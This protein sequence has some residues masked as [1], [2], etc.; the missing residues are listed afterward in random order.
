MTRSAQTWLA[1]AAGAAFTL[2]VPACSEPSREPGAASRAGA[3]GEPRLGRAASP[4]QGGATEA[5]SRFAVALVDDDGGICSG[6]LI[7][8]NLVLTARHCVADDDGGA[9][10]DCSQD[11]FEAPLPASIFRVDTR[12]DADFATAAHEVTQIFVPADTLFCGNDIA[13]V[14]LATPVDAATATP[15]VPAIDPPLTDRATYGSTITAIGYGTT[16]PSASDD[17]KRRRRDGIA[18]TCV[19]GDATLGCSLSDFD[20]TARELGAGDGLCSGDSGSGAYAPSSLVAGKVPVVT[21]VLSRSVDDAGECIDAVYTRTDTAAALLVRAAEAAAT[22][23]GYPLPAWATP[24]TPDAGADAGTLPDAAPPVTPSP[25][26]AS[27]PA[28][29]S[30]TSASSTDDDGCTVAPGRAALASRR[31]GACGSGWGLSALVVAAL[32][33]LRRRYAPSATSAAR[34]L[35]RARASSRSRK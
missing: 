4:I 22:A 13:L 35:S 19:P 5:G 10:V 1:V 20:I 31:G 7:A 12:A 23:G 25:V 17:G 2:A 9:T 34:R 15:A 30:P 24:T 14:V 21:G 18:L 33:A 16:S 6:T 11:R 3:G 29:A 27:E 26:D 8:P 32:G 28:P